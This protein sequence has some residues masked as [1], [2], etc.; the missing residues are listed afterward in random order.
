MY[1]FLFCVC[2]YIRVCI[3]SMRNELFK[4]KENEYIYELF[5]Q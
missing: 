4:E 1:I 2:T 5:T 3:F